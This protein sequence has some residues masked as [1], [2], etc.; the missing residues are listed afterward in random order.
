MMRK[1]LT[2]LGG[3]TVWIVAASLTALLLVQWWL[4]EQRPGLLRSLAYTVIPAAILVCTLAFGLS[5][6]RFVAA[7]ALLLAVTPTALFSL[8]AAH[9]HGALAVVFACGA[10]WLAVGGIR[11]VGIGVTTAGV[12]A[13]SGIV[14]WVAASPRLD[15]ATT[16]T[17]RD[18][19]SRTGEI[20]RAAVGVV[21]QS[22]SFVLATAVVAWWCMVGVLVGAAVF[23]GPVVRVR[24]RSAAVVP[25]AVLAFV[26]T[27]WWITWIRGAASG[28]GG[29]WML[30]SAVAYVGGSTALDRLTERRIGRT[31]ALGAVGI[32]VASVVQQIRAVPADAISVPFGGR[33]TLL[34]VCVVSGFVLVTW[35]W[36]TSGARRPRGVN[37]IGYH[38]SA[39]GLGERARELVAT[40]RAAGIPVSAWNVDRTESP[41]EH[42][43]DPESDGSQTVYRTSIAVVTALELPNL[44][45]SHSSLMTDVDSVIGYWFWEL[46]SVPE[47]HQHAIGLVDEIWTPSAF[48]F[49]AYRAA[50]MKPVRLV[51]LGVCEPDPDDDE[52]LDLGLDPNAFVFLVSFDHL[53]VIERKNPF[54]AIEAFKR[55]F[56]RGDE[57][58]ALVIKTINGDVRTASSA[59]LTEAASTDPR[60]V[61]SDGHLANSRHVALI[62]E[63]DALISLH[64][65]EG[66][67]LHAA[68]AMW[69]GT[70][71]IATRYSGTLDLMDNDCAALV[72]YQLVPVVNGDGAYPPEAEWADP[73][74]DD[75]AQLMR[76]LVATPAFGAGLAESARKRMESQPPRASTGRRIASLLNN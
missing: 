74:L 10:M 26:V 53:S 67:G 15:E 31:V 65:S 4:L 1:L 72:D 54:G 2:L 71:V 45:D 22:P 76:Q 35:I 63:A 47:Q 56:P 28:A 3:R 61:V 60:I 9:R 30:S 51:P 21:G 6:K 20:T 41:S 57:A 66:L 58:V 75:A 36:R 33:A 49:D 38:T 44:V 5:R 37:V 29:T 23:G 19:T 8:A 13:L 62:G 12:A 34:G 24:G 64:R 42:P 48:V 43:L 50:T 17:R 55:A 70:P 18:V 68:E 7:G 59:R 46:A 11:D 27:A 25:T 40:L 73:N 39:S 16:L 69:L 14:L 32:W 52:R